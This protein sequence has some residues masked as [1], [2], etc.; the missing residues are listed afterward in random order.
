MCLK[1]FVEIY[2]Y[3]LS[4]NNKYE[5]INTQLCMIMRHKIK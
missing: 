4:K 5:K 2:K 3:T 1:I